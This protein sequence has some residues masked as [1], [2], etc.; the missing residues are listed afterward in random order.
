M[1]ASYDRLRW[2]RERPG[3]TVLSGDSDALAQVLG[4]LEV[5]GIIARPLDVDY[6]FHSVGDE[7]VLR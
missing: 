4:T 1:I 3:S 7:S 6:A 5:R 2:P